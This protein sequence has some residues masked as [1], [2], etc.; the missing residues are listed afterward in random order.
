MAVQAK[1]FQSE[2][3]SLRLLGPFPLHFMLPLLLQQG[4]YPAAPALHS[5]SRWDLLAGSA[6]IHTETIVLQTCA[7]H[8]STLS[9]ASP[10][11]LPTS[12][13]II[14]NPSSA[15]VLPLPFQADWNGLARPSNINKGAELQKEKRGKKLGEETGG[16]RQRQWWRRNR[17]G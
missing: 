1:V 4:K 11:H 6:R 7:A 2:T 5:W 12:L 3:P 17:A 16:G 10:S 15:S 14:S 13:P 8:P 9:S